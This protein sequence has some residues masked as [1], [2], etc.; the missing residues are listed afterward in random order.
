M[1]TVLGDTT[2]ITGVVWKAC[3][4]FYDVGWFV[5]LLI[6]TYLSGRKTTHQIPIFVCTGSCFLS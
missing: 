6:C 5:F 1:D 4:G 2:D 3:E